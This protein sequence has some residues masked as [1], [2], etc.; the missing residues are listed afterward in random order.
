M[1]GTSIPT[2]GTPNFLHPHFQSEVPVLFQNTVAAGGSM[3]ETTLEATFAVETSL[4]VCNSTTGSTFSDGEELTPLASDTAGIDFRVSG[5]CG[6]LQNYLL[7]QN[8]TC[9]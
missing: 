1:T 3:E 9:G 5:T 7:K 6:L 2:T 4:T 8:H